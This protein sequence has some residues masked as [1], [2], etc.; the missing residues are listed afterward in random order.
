MGRAAGR[1][2][3]MKAIPYLSFNGDCEEAVR[4]YHAALGGKLEIMRYED[5]PAGGGMPPAGEGWAKKVMHA[6]LGFADGAYIYFSD[7]FEGS[8]VA[9]GDYAT[10]H[11]V[12][13][14]EAK[15][16]DIVKKLSAGGRVTMPP[17]K[18]F[19]GSVYGSLVDKF[20]VP[21]GVEFELGQ[22]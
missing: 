8:A 22:A 4:F 6:S 1:E 19:W 12:V 7:S 17:E 10:V 16:Y 21:W 15:V 2:T 11:V 18:T 3:Y 9:K 5:L 13:D 14:A 20:G